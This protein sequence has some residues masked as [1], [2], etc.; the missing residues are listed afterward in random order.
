[1]FHQNATKRATCGYISQAPFH[2]QYERK[3]S[4]NSPFELLCQEFWWIIWFWNSWRSHKFDTELKPNTFFDEHMCVHQVCLRI[5][6]HATSESSLVEFFE[7]SRIS[8]ASG[9]CLRVKLRAGDFLM[10]LLARSCEQREEKEWG[11]G[12]EAEARK[13]AAPGGIW[14]ERGGVHGAGGAVSGVY[15]A[16]G[17]KQ[18]VAERSK[19]FYTLAQPAEG[20]R[21][22]SPSKKM[23]LL[24]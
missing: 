23:K 21:V 10:V 12:A 4:W 19:T 8:S 2:H 17:G 20:S 22:R 18:S 24:V 15:I 3:I 14:R 11:V 1:M 13:R 16:R 5:A 7:C 9:I 6:S